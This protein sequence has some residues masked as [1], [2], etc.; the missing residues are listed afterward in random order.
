[1]TIAVAERTRVPVDA[2][3][4]FYRRAFKE[5]GLPAEGAATTA[6]IIVGADVYGIESHGAAL[7]RGY[8]RR[9][10]I[11]IVNPTP[12]IRVVSE[13]PGTLVLDGDN[14]P[15]PVVGA[16]AMGQAIEKARDS[17]VGTVVVRNSNHFAALANYSLMAAAA[18]MAGMTM[19]ATGPGVIPTFGAA[20]VLGTNPICIAFPGG[21]AAKPFLIDM[22]TSVVALGKVGV[23]RREG[24]PLPD[25]WAYDADLRPTTDATTAKYLTTLGGDRAH[26]SQKGYGLS[27]AV[28][29]FTGILSGGKVSAEISRAE[30]PLQTAHH[31]TAW[32]VDAFVP[33]GDYHARFDAYMQILHDCPPAPGHA[34]VLVPGDPEWAEEDDRRTHGIPLNPHVRA[35]LEAV[36]T[37]LAIAFV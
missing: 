2:L 8:I 14:G 29:L 23:H 6:R 13:F 17:G 20:P 19:T 22:S 28:D 3:E 16:Y 10:R 32:R 34:R 5:V 37:E 12:R 33:D 9:L 4:D 7:V 30:V 35:D 36:A 18:G 24:K 1:M 11:G 21:N 26:G 27:V 25:G 31:F 15:G